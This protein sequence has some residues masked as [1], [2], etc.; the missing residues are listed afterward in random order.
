MTRVAKYIS[1]KLGKHAYSGLEVQ[2]VA[3]FAPF[4]SLIRYSI[5]RFASLKLDS[6][7]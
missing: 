4:A 3:F 2:S 6:K 5:A 1:L 7:A